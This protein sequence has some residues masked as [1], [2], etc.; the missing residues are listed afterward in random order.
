MLTATAPL[1]RD[2]IVYNELHFFV[3]LIYPQIKSLFQKATPGSPGN[4]GCNKQH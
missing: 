1:G 4:E 3:V 2:T